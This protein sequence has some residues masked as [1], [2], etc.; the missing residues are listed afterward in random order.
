MRGCS[1]KLI[2]TTFFSLAL[3]FLVPLVS[4]AAITTDL[5]YGSKSPQVTELQN[6]LISKGYLQGSATGT[7]LA[8]TLAAVKA[9]QKANGLSPTGLVGPQTRA[10]INTLSSATVVKPSGADSTS[11]VQKK[12][13]TKVATPLV[14]PAKV[15]SAFAFNPAWKDAVVNLFCTD[16]SG[17]GVTSGSGVII[18]PR[19]VILTNAH[20][21]VYNLFSE[22][23]K[24]S[25]YDCVVRVGSPA[26]PLYRARL[27]Y[28]SEKFVKEIAAIQY[29]PQT[30]EDNTVYGEH[31]YAF[32]YITG[33]Y[34]ASNTVPS[35]FPYVPMSTGKT[36]ATGEQVY[37]AGYA[38]GFLGY[39]T[40]LK[41]LS[42]IASPSVVSGVKSVGKRTS[43]DVMLFTGNIAGQQGSSG[44]AVFARDGTVAGLP[45]FFAE[46]KGVS[47]AE[48]VLAAISTE[49]IYSD[50][51][52][53]N[54]LT[55]SEYLQGDLNKKASD[56]REN[57]IRR[58][59]R[60]FAEMWKEKNEYIPGFVG[61]DMSTI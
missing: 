36:L 29:K 37:L 19:G 21:V 2:Q 42:Q 33:P 12:I 7:F 61:Y 10:L 24:P 25:L 27:I 26:S 59:I 48:K 5:R 20:V 38:A 15:G 58:Y 14:A 9:F 30:L 28:I 53:E 6:F 44:G 47:T 8:K 43:P 31:D 4:V 18:D 50:F 34:A 40:L 41:N 49:Y 56:Y 55:V 16:R 57:E 52:S 35:T 54:G 13:D 11:G 17:G 22:W 45:T 3:V 23:P 1:K 32:L 39:E 51:S 60:I 46:D